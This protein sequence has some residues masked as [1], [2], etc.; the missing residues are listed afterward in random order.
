M[1][2]PYAGTVPQT[3][4]SE[5]ETGEPPSDRRRHVLFADDEAGLASIVQRLL[6]LEGFDVTICSGGEEAVARFDPDQHDLVLTD[7]GMPDLT[8]LEV[9]A[10]VRRRSPTTPVILVTGW[11][12]DL[13]S[14]APP[15]GVTAV[16]S[17]P[18]RL[19]TLVE[20]V[21]LALNE[22][23]QLPGATGRSDTPGHAPSR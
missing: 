10:A 15:A 4:E 19:G 7:Y 6:L 14:N 3:S 17:K 1:E 16:I 13:D 5:Q 23:E 22:K 12:S 18:F 20:A 9:A 21:R 8:G 2:L 11:G